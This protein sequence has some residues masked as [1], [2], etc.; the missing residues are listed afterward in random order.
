MSTDKIERF[1][2]SRES[3]FST[4]R[5]V[6]KRDCR[7]A[8]PSHHELLSRGQIFFPVQDCKDCGGRGLPTPST[9]K[10]R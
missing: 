2:V 1:Y 10:E 5:R 6:H 8:R 9:K 7:H 4:V 3:R